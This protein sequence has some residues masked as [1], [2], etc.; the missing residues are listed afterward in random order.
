MILSLGV[1]GKESFRKLFIDLNFDSLDQLFALPL[2]LDFRFEYKI[3]NYF[4]FLEKVLLLG[5]HQLYDVLDLR[6]VDDQ[7]L[8]SSHLPL[9]VDTFLLLN[10]DIHLLSH[11]LTLLF[12]CLYQGLIICK[13]FQLVVLRDLRSLSEARYS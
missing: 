3:F 13:N 4:F 9:I 8:I 6:V 12:E 10:L 11:D 1:L 2:M 5:S 7:S